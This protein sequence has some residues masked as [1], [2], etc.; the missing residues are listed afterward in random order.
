[1]LVRVCC[2]LVVV[3]CSSL[4][5]VVARCLLCAVVACLRCSLFVAVCCSLFVVCCWF[6]VACV[7]CGVSVYDLRL[8]VVFWLLL[9]VGRC[10]ALLGV[11]CC[12]VLAVICWLLFRFDRFLLRV[13]CLVFGVVWWLLCV[14]LLFGVVGSLLLVGVRCLFFVAN[15][16]LS[17]FC[18]E[19][20]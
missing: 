15:R 13:A 5:A 2:L 20:G 4:R 6:V 17:S 19:N 16:C 1:M 14:V 18:F 12:F 8:F 10:V 11:V 9:H 7:L 3:F